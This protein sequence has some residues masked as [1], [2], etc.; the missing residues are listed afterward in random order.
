[1]GSQKCD[2]SQIIKRQSFESA[3]NSSLQEEEGGKNRQKHDNDLYLQKLSWG[4]LFSVL[5]KPSSED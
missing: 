5:K 4:K 3:S 1:M 2:L